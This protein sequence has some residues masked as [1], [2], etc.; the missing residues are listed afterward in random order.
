MG[1]I[2][3]CGLNGSGKTTLGEKLAEILKY[4]F[5]NDEEYYFLQSEIPFSQSRT[6]AQAKEYILSCLN[7]Y[8][9]NVMVSSRGDM[10]REINVHYDHV[11]YLSAPA[12]LRMSRIEKR[13]LER[14]GKRVCP[15]G[16]MYEQQKAF[17]DFAA[18]R[19]E[20]KTE[21]WLNTISCPVTRLDGKCDISDNI[22]F[23]TSVIKQTT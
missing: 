9:N 14:F 7:K 17:H 10:G 3:L 1:I 8:K 13:D 19:T 23:L 20:E 5:L 6:E 21:K 12:E 16:D 11:V 4:R 2:L 18:S 22:V 15:G